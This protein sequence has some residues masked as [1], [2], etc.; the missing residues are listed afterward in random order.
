MSTVGTIVRDPGI[1][2]LPIA[3]SAVTILRGQLVAV[4]AATHTARLAAT[5]DRIFGIATSDSDPDLLSVAVAAKGGYT[6][7]VVVKTGDVVLVGTPLFQ[8]QTTFSQATI[9]STA[10]K[11]LGWAVNGN[12]DALGNIEMAF[13]LDVEA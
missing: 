5:G 13:F 10:S 11:A 2:W 1:V 6:I 9:T 4:D 7:S 8:D 3:S 12:R